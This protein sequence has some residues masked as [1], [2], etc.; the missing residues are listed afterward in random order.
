M[1]TFRGLLGGVGKILRWGVNSIV[2]IFLIFG[3]LVAIG[4]IYLL[5]TGLLH[6]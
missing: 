1:M 2:V 6:V 4:V 5:I 3:T